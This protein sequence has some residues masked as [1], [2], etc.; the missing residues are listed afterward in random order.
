[1]DHKT[2]KGTRIHDPGPGSGFL[3]RSP[4]DGQVSTGR[5]L[6]RRRPRRPGFLNFPF[7]SGDSWLLFQMFAYQARM[8]WIKIGM[9]ALT[10][11]TETRDS[12][13]QDG[14]R[15]PGHGPYLIEDFCLNAVVLFVI[16]LS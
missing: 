2:V 10:I 13:I 4:Q 8:Q 9:S 12:K 7:P 14:G 1:M 6:G 16:K 15:S 11:S 5:V 3:C